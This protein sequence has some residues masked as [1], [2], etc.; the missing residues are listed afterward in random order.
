MFFVFFW[1][2]PATVN[3]SASF[4]SFICCSYTHL[5]YTQMIPFDN[6][7]FLLFFSSYFHCSPLSVIYVQGTGTW[8]NQFLQPR[9]RLSSLQAKYPRTTL[10]MSPS[11]SCLKLSDAN[12]NARKSQLGRLDSSASQR[13]SS[14]LLTSSSMK[15][16]PWVP[17]IYTILWTVYIN[18]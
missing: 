2:L 1:F 6:S 8:I 7:I 16:K 12:D 18:Y 4:Y 11:G 5:Q 9:D 14:S 17:S 10:A 15:M 13:Q 3:S